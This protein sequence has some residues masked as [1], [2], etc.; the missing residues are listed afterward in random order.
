M[1][2]YPPYIDRELPAFTGSVI[3]VPFSLNKTV[4][5]TDFD[6]VAI[7]IKSVQSNSLKVSNKTTSLITYDEKTKKWLAK[8]DLLDE[9]FKPL[10]GQYYKVQIA[11]VDTY[12]VEEIV[13]EETEEGTIEKIETREINEAGYYSTVGIVKYTTNPILMIQNLHGNKGTNYHEY[14]YTGVYRQKALN[15]LDIEYD[16]TE[17]VYT[18]RFDIYDSYYNLHETSGDLL[19]NSSYDTETYESTDTW[20][21]SIDL[22]PNE[23]YTITY[24]V[25]TLNGLE[26]T[27]QEYKIIDADTV[28]MNLPA[29]LSATMNF[30]EGYMNLALKNNKGNKI[31]VKC[32]FVLVRASDK[33]NFT[34]WNKIYDFNLINELPEKVIWQDFTVEQGVKYKYGIQAYNEYDLFTNRLENIEGPVLADF[35]DAF[36]F[37]GERQLKIRYNSKVSNFR[38]TRLEAKYDTIGSKYPFIFRNG[39]VDYKEFPI[40]GLLSYLSDPEDLFL[41]INSNLKRER[42]KTRS[43]AENIPSAGIDL[44]SEVIKNERDFKLS[45]L[46]W[47]NNGKPKLFKSPVEGNYVIRLLN[48]SLT[49]EDVLGRMLHNFNATAY[50]V[51][52]YDYK[53]LKLYNFLP[54]NKAGLQLVMRMRN[55]DLKEHFKSIYPTPGDKIIIPEGAYFLFFKNQRRSLVFD[56]KYLN[57]HSY[58]TID[59]GNVTGDY[60]LPIIDTPVVELI[61]RWGVLEDHAEVLYGYYDEAAPTSRCLISRVDIKDRIIQINGDSF[62]ENIIDDLIDIKSKIGNVYYLRI[63]RK[64]I[65]K[66]YEVIQ[67]ENI[68]DEKGNIKPTIVDRKFYRDKRRQEEYNSWND[69]TLYHIEREN[70]NG[71]REWKWYSGSIQKSLGTQE[72]IYMAKV[73]NEPFIDFKRHVMGTGAE[74]VETA[75]RYDLITNAGPIES[76]YIGNGLIADIVYQEKIIEYNIENVDEFLIARRN[77]YQQSRDLYLNY[78]NSSEYDYG[79]AKILENQMNED[80]GLYLYDLTVKLKKLEEDENYHYVL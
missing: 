2:L 52:P 20:R 59:V 9:S 65:E 23:W 36:L 19:H 29:T 34:T 49:P 69:I 80:Y 64:H 61:Y 4:N 42:D 40:S 62:S 70:I 45:V 30:D 1:K 74:P 60:H 47:L 11:F 54:D 3:T 10:I 7:I 6:K 33:D 79:Q 37:D 15:N 53:N 76:L 13:K 55:I 68:E 35:E 27:S 18:Y 44:T 77:K 28:D 71:T 16:R 72:P 14:E 75:A 8:F 63:T 73:N 67:V 46:D 56:I 57:S 31:R 41:E 48:V 17:K 26:L 24:S 32:D 22:K 58:T 43:E 25:K 21:S 50:E 5:R 66:L 51:A 39:V 38:N 78:L 12:I